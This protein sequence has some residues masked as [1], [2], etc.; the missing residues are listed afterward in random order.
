M[1]RIAYYR[2][3]TGGQSIEVQRN[4]LNG[5][6]DKEFADH[7]ISGK[8]LAGQRAGFS[9][10]LSYVREGDTLHVFAIDRLGRDA[11]DIQHTVRLLLDKGVT[12]EVRGLGSIA[13]GVGELIVAVL[14]QIAQMERDAIRERTE[15]GRVLARE[16]LEATGLTHRGKKSLGRRTACD[17]DAVRRWRAE[18]GAS[19]S[20]TAR[21]FGISVT[22]VKRYLAGVHGTR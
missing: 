17:P 5:P 11:I 20:V 21:Q 22:S 12:L 13:R 10:M 16:T 9:E 1:S 14:A 2:V 15:A 3:S 8:V 7:G 18:T 19:L 4:A 6:F